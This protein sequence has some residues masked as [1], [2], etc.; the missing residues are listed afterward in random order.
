MKRIYDAAFAPNNNGSHH[1]HL[2]TFW[3][4]D[5]NDSRIKGIWYSKEEAHDYVYNHYQTVFVSETGESVWVYAY[6]STTNPDIKWVQTEA[7]GKLP[8]NLITLAKR[9]ARGLRNY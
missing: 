8:D 3:W 5:N 2:G 1:S 9:H 4:V 7:D 6:N